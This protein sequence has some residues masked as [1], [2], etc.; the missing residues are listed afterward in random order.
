MIYY[1]S[2]R[3]LS[4]PSLSAVPA[5]LS[6]TYRP[7]GDGKEAFRSHICHRFVP[8]QFGLG[9]EGMQVGLISAGPYD[10]ICSTGASG[11]SSQGQV[12]TPF[13][14]MAGLRPVTSGISRCCRAGGSSSPPVSWARLNAS[15][16]P[17]PPPPSPQEH[18]YTDASVVGWGAHVGSLTVSGHWQVGMMAYLTSQVQSSE[19]QGYCPF[20]PS[21]CEVLAVFTKCLSPGALLGGACMLSSHT[22]CVLCTFGQLGQMVC[23]SFSPSS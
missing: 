12:S 13:L 16:T 3:G 21:F 10:V 15:H 2:L 7:G 14:G 11:L 22:R 17:N 19:T 23:G 9:A 1:S 4:F 18:L 6:C 20:T 5:C 8:W